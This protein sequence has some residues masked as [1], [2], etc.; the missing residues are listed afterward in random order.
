MIGPLPDDDSH[1]LAFQQAG[2]VVMYSEPKKMENALDG[3]G[4]G[5]AL[6]ALYKRKGKTALTEQALRELRN[7]IV[8]L[9]HSDFDEAAEQFSPAAKTDI[10]TEKSTIANLSE[11]LTPLGQIAYLA[12][13]YFGCELIVVT[14]KQNER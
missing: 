8:E 7:K 13:T 2:A 9:L 14:E 4:L 3:K 12:R 10:E 11:R 1:F 5:E 6:L